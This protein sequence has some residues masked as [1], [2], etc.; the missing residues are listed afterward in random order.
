MLGE[1]MAVPRIS[2]LP[3]IIA[4]TTGKVEMEGFEDKNEQKI[5]DDLTKKAV[6]IGL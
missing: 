3:Y 5:I 4:S 1:K 2:D 6:L